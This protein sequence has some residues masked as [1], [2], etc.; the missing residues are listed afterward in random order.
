MAIGVGLDVMGRGSLGFLASGV[1]RMS[2]VRYLRLTSR[3]LSVARGVW[4]PRPR[5]RWCLHQ[6]R[7]AEMLWGLRRWRQL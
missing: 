6:G 5:L 3:R 1:G 2:H 4:I 7:R